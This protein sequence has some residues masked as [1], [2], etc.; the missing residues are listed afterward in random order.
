MSN[1]FQS[2]SEAMVEVVRTAGEAVVQVNARRRLPASGV[3]WSAEGVIITAHH[4]VKSSTISVTL[5]DGTT[6]GAQLVGRDATTDLAVLRVEG[7]DLPA[8]QW[9]DGEMAV[10][11][12]VLALA[13]PGRTVQAT[14]GI[15]SAL[16]DA[17]RTGAGGQIDRYLQ[18]DVLMYPG[19][20]GGA[21]V[22]AE[23]RTLGINSSALVRGTSITVPATT[24][25]RV[26]EALL[27]H[28]RVQRGYLGV[29]TQAVRL[30]ENL[31]EEVGQDTGL[32]IVAVEADS[33]AG[34]AG[35]VLGDT[36]ISLD[37]RPVRSH[38]DLVALL[39]GDRVGQKAPLGIVRGGEM[40][41][42]NVIIGERS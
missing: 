40:Q 34:E 17:W 22:D 28:G 6:V 29:S 35:L 13:R 23:G 27:A 37:G 41:T 38:D 25:G 3:V 30:P 20:S 15:V 9:N 21:L 8:A 2:H 42:R 14:V 31:R 16:G 19:F 26:A 1:S 5:A 18:T 4:V 10:G 32:L 7:G 36:I 39:S 11:E 12:L 33:P 24:V